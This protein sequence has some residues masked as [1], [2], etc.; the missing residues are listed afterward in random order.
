VSPAPAT[1]SGTI[2]VLRAATYL[3]ALLIIGMGA[4]LAV[5][6]ATS[7]ATTRM[8][9]VGFGLVIAAVVVLLVHQRIGRIAMA[10]AILLVLAF[11][12]PATLVQ[13]TYSTHCVAGVPCDPVPNSQEGLRLGIAAVL[14]VGSLLTA[15]AGALRPPRSSAPRTTLRE[16]A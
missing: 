10:S 14:L 11:V 7:P 9:Y 8:T 1:P 12:V 4:L 13:E 6:D 16:F 2:Q 3:I 15:A 5:A